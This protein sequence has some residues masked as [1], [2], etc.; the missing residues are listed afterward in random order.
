[1]P[2]ALRL[3]LHR[4]CVEAE[5]YLE[6]AMPEQALQTLQRRAS[7]V[8]GDARGCYL[9][10]EAL[11]EMRQ[12]RAAI[13]PLRRSLDLIPDD[14][15]V[16]LAVAWCYK[17]VGRLEDAISA[18]EHAVRVEPGDALLHYNLA[19][20]C[21]LAR[22]RRRALQHLANALDIDGNFR[23][24]VID[25]RDFDPLRSDPLFQSLTATVS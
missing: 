23:E 17:R 5:G 10:G 19:C 13:Y 11:R 9:L 7:L 8:H 1:M 22:N 12:Y 2:V 18:L 21:S 16:C 24:M 6:L 4:T 20:Y 15:R 3:Q 14:T 25:E